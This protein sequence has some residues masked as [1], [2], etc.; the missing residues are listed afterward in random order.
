MASQTSLLCW[1]QSRSWRDNVKRA[2][3]FNVCFR[4]KS[5]L[6]PDRT[7]RN[8]TYMGRTHFSLT[9]LQESIVKKIALSIVVTECS[10]QHVN[11]C[12]GT[13]EIGHPKEVSGT[14]IL[15]YIW[16]SFFSECKLPQLHT[17]RRKFLHSLWQQ[18]HSIRRHC[19]SRWMQTY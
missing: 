16:L 12:T 7:E 10:A 8:G 18:L 11:L 1:N 17:S 5:V 3:V 14:N 6:E 9:I 13:N 4:A 2:K 19:M 15:P